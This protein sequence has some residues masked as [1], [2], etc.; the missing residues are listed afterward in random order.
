M[1]YYTGIGSRETPLHITELMNRIGEICAD[2]NIILR[3]GGAEGADSAFEV[4]CDSVNGEKEI[5]IPWNNF[6]GRRSSMKGVYVRGNDV[7]SRVIAHSL[8][9]VFDRLGRG[10]QALHTRNVNQVLG[11]DSGSPEPS[12]FVLFYAPETSSGNVKGG[13][14][15]AVNLAKRNNIPCWNMW[16]NSSYDQ[17]LDWIDSIFKEKQ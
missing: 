2:H 15:T 14:A 12:S 3:S 6:N 13:T 9:P 10:A 7:H 8:H 17:I 5:F 4:G 1:R 16:S 11:K